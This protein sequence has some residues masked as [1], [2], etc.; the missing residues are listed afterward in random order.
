[1]KVSQATRSFLDYHRMNSKKN[2]LRNYHHLLTEFSAQFGDR[3]T[4]SLT[5]E[6]ILSFLGHLTEGLK[7]STKRLRFS[8]LRA[9]FTFIINTS[10]ERFPNPCDAPMLRKISKDYIRGSKFKNLSDSHLAP[11]HHF[12]DQPVSAFPALRSSN[13]EH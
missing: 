2:T 7:Q 8:L 12:Q 6:E 11:C 9:F 3:E 1:M 4:E 5:S 10:N 13:L